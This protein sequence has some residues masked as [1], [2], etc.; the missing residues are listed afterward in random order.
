MT[1]KLYAEYLAVSYMCGSI[2]FW[3]STQR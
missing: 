1:V 3:N 2:K